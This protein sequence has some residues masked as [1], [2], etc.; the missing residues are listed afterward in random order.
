MHLLTDLNLQ[1]KTSHK[2]ISGRKWA[3]AQGLKLFKEI[4]GIEPRTTCYDKP[5]QCTFSR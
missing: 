4:F 1:D 2:Q 3:C 5:V